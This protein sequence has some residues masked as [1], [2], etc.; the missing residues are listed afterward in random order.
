MTNSVSSGTSARRIDLPDRLP[1]QSCER[2]RERQRERS[3]MSLGRE[4]L[5]PAPHGVADGVVMGLL[6]GADGS[7]PILSLVWLPRAEDVGTNRGWAQATS[8]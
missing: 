3:C 1:L 8:D 6:A 5:V 4:L 7:R 2:D